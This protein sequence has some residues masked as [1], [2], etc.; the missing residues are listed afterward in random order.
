[1]FCFY[2]RATRVLVEIRDSTISAASFQGF[3]FP[4]VCIP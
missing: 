3:A 4:C 2:S 1:M